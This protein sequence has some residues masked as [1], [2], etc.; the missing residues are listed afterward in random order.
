[1]GVELQWQK[2]DYNII[3]LLK[4]MNIFVKDWD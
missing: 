3:S 2:L 1:M 4:Q